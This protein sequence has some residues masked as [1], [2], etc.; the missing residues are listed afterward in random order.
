MNRVCYMVGVGQAQITIS[1]VYTFISHTGLLI[2]GLDT[3][4]GIKKKV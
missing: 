4:F 2:H 1:Q 3:A